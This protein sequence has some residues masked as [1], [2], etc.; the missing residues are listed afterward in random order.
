MTMEVVELVSNF[1]TE[2]GTHA[3]D[4]FCTECTECGRVSVDGDDE[5][6]W[7]ETFDDEGS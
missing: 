2:C 7:C 4:C 1:C 6:S 5:C 3:R